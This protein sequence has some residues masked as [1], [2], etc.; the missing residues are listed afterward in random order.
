MFLT[1]V[2][3]LDDGHVEDAVTVTT[4]EGNDHR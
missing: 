3:H 2:N 4:H 1:L